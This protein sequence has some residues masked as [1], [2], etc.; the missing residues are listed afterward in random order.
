MKKTAVA[1]FI[2]LGVVWDSHFIFVK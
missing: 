1:A 2:F